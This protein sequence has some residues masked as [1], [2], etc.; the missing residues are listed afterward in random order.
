M[1]GDSS[2]VAWIVRHRTPLL[3]VL[4][5]GI[6]VAAAGLRL[7]TMDE[8]TPWVVGAAFVLALV[9]AHLM[10]ERAPL[11]ALG[12]AAVVLAI[13]I[14][15]T[16]SLSVGSLVVAGDIAYVVGLRVR[17]RWVDGAAILVGIA[18]AVGLAGLF[19]ADIRDGLLGLLVSLGV[20]LAGSVWW[21]REIRRPRLEAD[22]ERA[23]A[24]AIAEAARARH[25]EAIASERLRLAR[26]L[27]D[28]VAGSVSAIAL[29]SSAALAARHQSVDVLRRA[30]DGTRS[31]SLAA[32]GELQ[33]MIE[34]LRS[35]DVQDGAGSRPA[36]DRVLDDARDRGMTIASSWDTRAVDALAP[37]VMAAVTRVV[38]ESLT[39]A[40]RHARGAPVDLLVRVEDGAAAVRVSNRV[41]GI[42]T[43]AP[44]GAGPI[45]SGSGIEGM[46]ERVR[47]LGGEFSAGRVGAEWRVEAVIP[48]PSPEEGR[49]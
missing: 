49:S 35:P 2:A 36:L 21:G 17:G 20:V 38:Q 18:A 28:A 27:H 30:L 40:D 46:R 11:V 3:T 13:E 1:R 25:A 48:P 29:H 45:G 39:N 44:A 24:D 31:I 15:V 32:L 7:G 9:L 4:V 33:E 19:V 41:D 34:V 43:A 47:L 12:V 37:A 5:G 14:A 6:G 23:R 22:A 16:R 10:R 26:E 8:P 42:A